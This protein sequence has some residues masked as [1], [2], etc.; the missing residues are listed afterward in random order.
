L[1]PLTIPVDVTARPA[2]KLVQ[3]HVSH[4]EILIRCLKDL[5]EEP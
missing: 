2:V 3:S 5:Q 4:A 1:L